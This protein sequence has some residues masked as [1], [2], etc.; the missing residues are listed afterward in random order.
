[1]DK[2]KALQKSDPAA[3]GAAWEIYRER[4]YEGTYDP[5]CHATESLK[6][7]VTTHTSTPP[8][9]GTGSRTA[10]EG[11]AAQAQCRAGCRKDFA[12]CSSSFILSRIIEITLLGPSGPTPLGNTWFLTTLLRLKLI[13]S[14]NP[15]VKETLSGML[16]LGRTHAEAEDLRLQDQHHHNSIQEQPAM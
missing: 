7:F 1:M 9:T 11:T 6:T 12:A 14:A 15:N 3:G 16:A 10:E 2:I 8:L 13:R 5:S 4:N